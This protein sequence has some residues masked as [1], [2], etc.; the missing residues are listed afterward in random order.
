MVI[1]YLVFMNKKKKIIFYAL[2]SLLLLT[3]FFILFIF[4][5]S[6]TVW[7]TANEVSRIWE[8]NKAQYGDTLEA[9]ENTVKAIKNLPFISNAGLNEDGSVID[10]EYIFGGTGALWFIKEGAA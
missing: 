6:K 8:E 4:W 2:F 3:T 5:M 9:R 10:Y 1:N 7:T